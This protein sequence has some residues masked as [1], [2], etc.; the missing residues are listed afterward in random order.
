MLVILITILFI[1]WIGDFV[2]QTRW[3]AENKSKD[4]RALLL[5]VG[6]YAA[7]LFLGLS[8]FKGY[9]DHLPVNGLALFMAINVV[10]HLAIDYC[11]SRLNTYL[12][13]NQ[14]IAPFWWSI[15]F[16]Q[17]LHNATLLISAWYLLA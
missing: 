7:V 16:D 10:I 1:H 3:M 15:G 17:F 4:N 12:W 6:I 8:L 2:A 5:H 13:T 11:T 14:K 9:V